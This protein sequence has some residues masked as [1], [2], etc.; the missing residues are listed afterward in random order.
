MAIDENGVF[1]LG[2][3]ADAGTLASAIS[4]AHWARSHSI[5]K[6]GDWSESVDGTAHRL[7]KNGKG[8]SMPANFL[9][10][11]GKLDRDLPFR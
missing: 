8:K 10:G 7:A 3:G 5:L 2:T 1:F 9:A 6:G 4:R 11:K